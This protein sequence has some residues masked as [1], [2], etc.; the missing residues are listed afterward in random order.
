[1]FYEAEI[2]K[3]LNYNIKELSLFGSNSFIPNLLI[4][5]YYV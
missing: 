4:I 2:T 3:N 1:M 5:P